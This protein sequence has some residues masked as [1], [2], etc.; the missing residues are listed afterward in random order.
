M[1]LVGRLA[2]K[3]DGLLRVGGNAASQLIGLAKVELGVTIAF[4]GRFLP[5]GDCSGI[6][7]GPPFPHA[8]LDTCKR[9]RRQP[10]GDRK[11]SEEQTSELQSLMST[12]YAVFCLK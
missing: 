4:C 5:F 12:S 8:I 1:P 3:V 2:V 9:G 11:Q 6:I 7:A 10:G